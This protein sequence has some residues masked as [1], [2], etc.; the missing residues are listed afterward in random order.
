MVNEFFMAALRQDISDIKKQLEKQIALSE[1]L[2][3]QI[4]ALS[5]KQVKVSSKESAK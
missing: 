4:K 3:A 2:V 5:A 1:E